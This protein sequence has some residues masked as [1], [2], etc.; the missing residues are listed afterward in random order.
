MQGNTHVSLTKFGD[1]QQD[2]N[3][4]R[5]RLTQ[6]V[7][8]PQ[9]HC[10]VDLCLSEPRLLISRGKDFH[11]HILALP[12]SSPHLSISSFAW[13]KKNICILKR[14]QEE[15]TNSKSEKKKKYRCMHFKKTITVYFLKFEGWIFTLFHCYS[16]E[17]LLAQI[18]CFHI[19]SSTVHKA[20]NL[21]TKLLHAVVHDNVVYKKDPKT[22]NLHTFIWKLHQNLSDFIVLFT[23][24]LSLSL[25]SDRWQ[26]WTWST[27][28]TNKKGT[29]KMF[30]QFLEVSHRWFDLPSLWHH[31]D[32]TDMYSHD[33][34]QDRLWR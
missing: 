7:F 1:S 32:S 17:I 31:S 22:S 11:G 4:K 29:D 15:T 14:T 34:S 10:I 19:K 13:R 30:W 2:Q 24:T 5:N 8:M 16:S 18:W 20:T 28:H 3:I 9:Q 26:F 21:K 6:Y 33:C 12:L 25:T 23:V 27:T